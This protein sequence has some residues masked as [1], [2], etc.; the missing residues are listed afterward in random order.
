MFHPITIV[1]SESE[2]V[3]SVEKFLDS[4]LAFV[5]NYE[6]GGSDS[7]DIKKI[8]RAIK[9]LSLSIDEEG[10]RKEGFDI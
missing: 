2:L 1:S 5:K 7:D 4:G 8:I 10:L 6:M 3:L 9:D